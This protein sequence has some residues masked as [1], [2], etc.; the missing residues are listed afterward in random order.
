MASLRS[1]AADCIRRI[2]KEF[3]I[4]TARRRRLTQPVQLPALAPVYSASMPR[5]PIVWLLIAC[6]ALI[7]AQLSGAHAQVDEHGFAGSVQTTHDHHHD[8]GDDHDG[9]VDVDV[10]DL[11]I[12]AAKAVFLLLAVNVTM[13]L[14]PPARGVVYLEHEIRLPL[15]RRLRWRPPLRA[16]PR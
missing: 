15:R 7:G 13:F 1:V 11:G 4:R 14:L 8:Q 10:V 9:A 5:A 12:A 3:L 16:P 2:L 6:L